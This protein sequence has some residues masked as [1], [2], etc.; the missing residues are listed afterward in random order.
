MKIVY[1]S[2]TGNCKRFAEKLGF[3]TQPMKD[4]S[5]GLSSDESIVLVFPTVGF[6]KVPSPVIRFL[7][8]HHKNVKL[9]VSS[10]NRNWG[11]NFAI[12]ADTVTGKL[13][14]PS[15]KIELAGTADDVENVK[16]KI[17]EFM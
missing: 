1:F 4:A 8:Q 15:Y 7:K 17:A 14:I 11:P 9:V 5:V 10:G 6:G 13:E 3:E 16:Q 2:L 12:G